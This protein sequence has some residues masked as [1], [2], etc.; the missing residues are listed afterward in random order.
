MIKLSIIIPYYKTLP[1]TIKLL[2]RLIPQLTKE[3]ELLIIHNKLDDGFTKEERVKLYKYR[4]R[5]VKFY[6]MGK[7][8]RGAGRPR[9]IGLDNAKGEYIAFIDSDDMISDKYINIISDKIDNSVFDYC[10]ISWHGDKWGNVIIKDFPPTWNVAIWYCIYSRKLIGYHRFNEDMLIAEDKDFN[11]R[12]LRGIKENIEEV[13]YYYNCNRE[14]SIMYE[15]R[16]DKQ[17]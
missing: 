7:S 8:K 12:V 5:N 11:N 15:Y 14:G 13:L 16:K 17:K 6:E 4:Q 3:T 10:Y 9:N 1:F 2:D